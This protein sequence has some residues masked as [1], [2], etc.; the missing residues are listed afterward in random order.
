MA[1]WSGGTGRTRRGG[2]GVA[3][4]AVGLLTACAPAAPPVE[5]AAA[6]AP[7]P[8]QA[9]APWTRSAPVPV[10]AE[11]AVPAPVV[12]QDAAA[13]QAAIAA[14]A[15]MPVPQ[16][17][18]PT[19]TGLVV[20]PFVGVGRSPE[21]HPRPAPCGGHTSP[22]RVSPGV[23]PGPGGSAT[24][25]WQAGARAEVLGY[26]VSAVSQT[27][28]SGVQRAPLT[29]DAGQPADCGAV[30]VTFAGLT[31]GDAYVFWL[32]ER[33]IDIATSVERLVQIGTSQPVVIGR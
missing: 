2:V 24:V 1:G 28:R 16:P 23:E 13:A 11:P 26:R 3:L 27:L 15:G 9:A 7:A 8:T 4:A 22:R 17:P 30:T 14:D 21:L 12:D 31:P 32:E 5:V 25:T 33:T 29:R 18:R 6:T 20:S 19:R 10:A